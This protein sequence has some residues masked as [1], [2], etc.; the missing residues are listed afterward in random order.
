MLIAIQAAIKKANNCQPN[1]Q[2]RP[3]RLLDGDYLCEIGHNFINYLTNYVEYG[4][5]KK[6]NIKA[7]RGAVAMSSM[8]V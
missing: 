2:T 4:I 6:T 5:V 3:H 7:D 8:R 1:K